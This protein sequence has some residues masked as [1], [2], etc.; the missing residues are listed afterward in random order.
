[1]DYVS[2]L[3]HLDASE[4]LHQ[5]LH[6]AAQLAVL[7][8]A[9]LIGLFAVDDVDL[10][11][12]RYV[13]DDGKCES[14]GA[15]AS[16]RRNA[17]ESA[18]LS[19]RAATEVLGIQAEWRDCELCMPYAAV[20]NGHLA[21]LLVLGQP[22]PSCKVLMDKCRSADSVVLR[23]GRPVLLVPYAG[24]FPH[25]GT[26]IMVAWNGTREAAHSIRDALPL[27][28]RA[29]FVD[30]IRFFSPHALENP[31]YVSSQHVVA[32]LKGHGVSPQLEEVTLDNDDETGEL[33]LSRVA[34]KNIDLLVMGA[35]G[36]S[37]QFEKILGGVTRTIMK[38]TTIPTLM[39]H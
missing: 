35:Y 33:L 1:M 39:S 15:L 28:K 13:F 2:I 26:S 10:G 12:R 6:I 31:W 24:W 29:A 8:N 19:F 17:A 37:R 9:K 27:L 34:D 23:C 3:V 21:D 11:A 22:D 36:R 14:Q 4:Q 7:H 25:T 18:R 16:R 5:R 20:I 30:V 32:W 38:S